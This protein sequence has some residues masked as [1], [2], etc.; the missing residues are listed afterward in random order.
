MR[1]AKVYVSKRLENSKRTPHQLLMYILR[2][3]KNSGQSRCPITVIPKSWTYYEVEKK[4]ITNK[5]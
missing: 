2:D 3:K 1:I 4:L 5:D